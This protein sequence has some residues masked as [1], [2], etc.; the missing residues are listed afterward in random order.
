MHKTFILRKEVCIFIWKWDGISLL[1]FLLVLR[2][3]GLVKLNFW[4]HEN[5][6]C[7]ELKVWIAEEGSGEGKEWHFEVVVGLGGNFEVSHVV[8]LVE[9]DTLGWDLSVTNIDLVADKND[10]D[11]GANTD[12]ITVPC[13]NVTVCGWGCNI[14]HDDSAVGFKVVAF[15]ETA[16]TFLASCIPDVVEDLAAGCLEN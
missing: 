9:C 8:L 7:C 3:E 13:D 5:W 11:V 6:S 15:T 1:E 2:D 16:E 14:E 10:W 12:E 4:W